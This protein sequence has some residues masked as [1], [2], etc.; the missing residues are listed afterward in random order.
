ME[1]AFEAFTTNSH[2]DV[3]IFS[4][5][6]YVKPQILQRC[7]YVLHAVAM[8]HA[9]FPISWGLFVKNVILLVKFILVGDVG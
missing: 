2:R 5:I 6:K 3:F 8:N 9:K 4:R 1:E 7:L